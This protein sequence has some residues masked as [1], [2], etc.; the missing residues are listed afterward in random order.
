MWHN[1]RNNVCHKVW[2]NILTQH[3]SVMTQFVAQHVHNIWH[4]IWYN[5]YDN[6]EHNLWNNT[7][8]NMQHFSWYMSD[9]T[10]FTY[11]T[12]CTVLSKTFKY[13]KVNTGEKDF[14]LLK[15]FAFSKKILLN[16]SMLYL[17]YVGVGVQG[18]RHILLRVWPFLPTGT[19]RPRICIRKYS[20]HS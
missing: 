14:H 3:M 1:T 7:W 9:T 18:P 8:H 19:S 2:L 17:S 20:C 15:E 5:M 10:F 6:A 12:Q 4:N 11:L 13:L 16:D